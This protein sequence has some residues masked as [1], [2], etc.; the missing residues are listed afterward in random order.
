MKKIAVFCFVAFAI[1][2]QCPARVM[3]ITESQSEAIVD[4]CASIKEKLRSVQKNDAKV[5]VYL[6]GYYESILTKFI[7]PLNV[8]LVENNLSNAEL[9]ENQNNF[10]SVKA[11]FSSDFI[12]YQQELELL[13]SMDCR[14]DPEEF[15]EKLDIVRQ[16]RK[17]M[18]Q[19]VLRVRSIISQHVRLVEKLKGKV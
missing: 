18:V 6:G 9:V 8:R 17:T 16:K 7:V 10:A 3:A 12:N 19:D 4:N 14:K 11:L 15:Y 13:V 5:R 1:F 2:C